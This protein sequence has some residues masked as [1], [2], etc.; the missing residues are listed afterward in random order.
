MNILEEDEEKRRPLKTLS[1]NSTILHFLESKNLWTVGDL[2][3]LSP[4]KQTQLPSSAQAV[5][6]EFQTKYGTTQ[7]EKIVASE[8]ELSGDFLDSPVDVLGLSQRPSN[9]L[10]RQGVRTVG[11]FLALDL[12]EFASFRHVGGKSVEEVFEMKKQLAEGGF[13]VPHVF[14]E[15]Y[16]SDAPVSLDTPIDV[17][18]LSER[19]SNALAREG[20]RTVGEFLALDPEEFASFRAV[21]EKSITEVARVRSGIIIALLPSE[22]SI[23]VLGLSQRPRNQLLRNGIRTVGEFLALDLEEFASFNEVGE[24]SVEEVI[25]V[26]SSIFSSLNFSFS[27][28][29]ITE[30][31]ESFP[32][33]EEGE[34]E[35]FDEVKQIF[36]ESKSTTEKNLVNEVANS[37]SLSPVEATTFFEKWLVELYVS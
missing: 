27:I 33:E 15:L 16:D 13:N 20:V 6:K 3:T 30:H 29:S 1:L 24:Q 28:E 12:E 5:I 2:L 34:G 37:F 26:K 22:I 9:A 14:P 7:G 32:E 4:H 17:L 8:E 21:G 23:D 25:T 35:K 11:E 18:G 19:P 36:Y 10:A 31:I